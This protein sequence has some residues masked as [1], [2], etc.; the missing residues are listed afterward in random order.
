MKKRI[1]CFLALALFSL[2]GI[3]FAN[4]EQDSEGL[5][6]NSTKP[7]YMAFDYEYH[8]GP[9]LRQLRGIV[10]DPQGLWQALLPLQPPPGARGSYGLIGDDSLLGQE[11]GYGLRQLGKIARRYLTVDFI[12]VVQPPGFW[13]L[14]I[15]GGAFTSIEA[16]NNPT[17]GW[18]FFDLRPKFE[19]DL[20]KFLNL[21]P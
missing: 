18:V 4:N 1:I 14:G 17:L 7:K 3:V 15:Q 9:Y 8:E 11:P 5:Q 21:V 2:S 19:A 13:D 20:K 10:K 16:L 12:Y 6:N